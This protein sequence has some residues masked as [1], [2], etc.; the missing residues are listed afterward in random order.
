MRADVHRIAGHFGLGIQVPLQC[1]RIGYR[2]TRKPETHD[3]RHDEHRSSNLVFL[4]H[5]TFVQGQGMAFHAFVDAEVTATEEP[6]QSRVTR[7][8]LWSRL[9][10]LAT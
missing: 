1:E 2:D 3:E 9:R 10:A 8:Q 6:L 5:Q 4:R 7:A